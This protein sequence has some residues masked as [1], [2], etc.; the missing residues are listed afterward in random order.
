MKRLVAVAPAAWLALSLLVAAPRA[1]R[2]VEFWSRPYLAE[3]ARC[4]DDSTVFRKTFDYVV[5]YRVPRVDGFTRWQPVF[6]SARARE[7]FDLSQRTGGIRERDEGLWHVIQL[8]AGYRA[9]GGDRST[10]GKDATRYP[11]RN[12]WDWANEMKIRVALGYFG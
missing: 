1:V 7:T 4:I 3:E 2:A 10:P 12:A 9:R 6:T 5:V 11:N 8:T